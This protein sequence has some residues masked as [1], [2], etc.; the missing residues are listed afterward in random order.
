MHQFRYGWSRTMRRGSSTESQNDTETLRPTTPTGVDDNH[1]VDS[2]MLATS[3]DDTDEPEESEDF[4]A[5]NQVEGVV[6]RNPSHRSL[7]IASSDRSTRNVHTGA[8]ARS[9]SEASIASSRPRSP[10]VSQVAFP[11][12]FPGLSDRVAEY[13]AQQTRLPPT[14]TGQSTTPASFVFGSPPELSPIVVSPASSSN[15]SFTLFEAPPGWKGS[16]DNFAAESSSHAQRK[17]GESIINQDQQQSNVGRKGKEPSLELLKDEPNYPKSPCANNCDKGKA[18]AVQ[19]QLN[20]LNKKVDGLD[21]R[22]SE[23]SKGQQDLETRPAPDFANERHAIDALQARMDEQEGRNTQS[24]LRMDDSAAKFR[25][26]EVTTAK[27]VRFLREDIESLQDGQQRLLELLEKTRGEI[28][29][30]Q[31]AR[32]S[33]R[34]RESKE[35]IEATQPGSSQRGYPKRS[36]EAEPRPVARRN[37]SD[38]NAQVGR[39]DSTHQCH[40]EPPLDPETPKRI[41]SQSATFLDAYIP[42]SW[43]WLNPG[44]PSTPPPRRRK[45][46]I[47]DFN[48]PPPICPPLPTTAPEAPGPSSWTEE[49]RYWNRSPRPGTDFRIAYNDEMRSWLEPGTM[50]LKKT[51]GRYSDNYDPRWTPL[52][53]RSPVASG[54]NHRE[55]SRVAED[56]GLRLRSYAA[57][58]RRAHRSPSPAVSPRSRKTPYASDY[59]DQK[60]ASSQ[61]SP[62]ERPPSNEALEREFDDFYAGRSDKPPP[63]TPEWS[64]EHARRFPNGCESVGNCIVCQINGHESGRP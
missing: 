9:N 57:G 60:Q 21:R 22:C 37:R 54:S 25:R 52:G 18:R 47:A 15:V 4:D 12:P 61:S 30:L 50:K 38:L 27:Q 6:E 10:P 43:T 34:Q 20:A 58:P 59:Q 41:P 53:L 8:S 48:P 1:D 51:A 45:P 40:P 14:A 26:L 62:V 23:L 32:I 11:S 49:Q 29:E 42:K 36:N 19:P 13:I 16:I 35:N 24:L 5:S 56:P 46:I 7:S 3:G 33:A 28:T 64:T 44:P 2:P 63:L 31:K 55:T 39:P 17:S